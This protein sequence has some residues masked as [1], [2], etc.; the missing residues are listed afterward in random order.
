MMVFKSEGKEMYPIFVCAKC[1]WS[2]HSSVKVCKHARNQQK[3]I[4]SHTA[5]AVSR[6]V[7]VAYALC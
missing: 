1:C 7:Y 6:Q 3:K 2:I 4:H 5:S